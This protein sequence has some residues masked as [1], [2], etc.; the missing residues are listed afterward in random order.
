MVVSW[1][2]ASKHAHTASGDAG[3]ADPG[4]LHK[5]RAGALSRRAWADFYGLWAEERSRKYPVAEYFHAV[6]KKYE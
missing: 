4:V 2:A 3:R 5:E 1:E 6:R